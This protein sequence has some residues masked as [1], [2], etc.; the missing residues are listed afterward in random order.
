MIHQIMK[1]PFHP[2]LILVGALAATSLFAQ[3]APTNPSPAPGPRNG[4]APSL[5]NLM[6]LLDK[7]HDGRISK[8]EATGNYAQRYSQW[9]ANGDGYATRQEIHD[10]RTKRGITDAGRPGKGGN[11]GRNSN[12]NAGAMEAALLKEPADWRM[13]TMPMPP[14]FAPAIK[15]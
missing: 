6:N 14:G 9:D 1:S 4:A 10:Y 5:D 15:L 2:V 8:A 12:A 11:P 13:E 7:D 3:D